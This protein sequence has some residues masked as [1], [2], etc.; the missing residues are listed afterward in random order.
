MSGGV[1]VLNGKD[2]VAM[3][4]QPYDSETL[5]ARYPEARAEHVLRVQASPRAPASKSARTSTSSGSGTTSSRTCAPAGSDSCSSRMR[6][7]RSS[8][9]SSSSST[10][11]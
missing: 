8:V 11:G 2:L 3:H 10:N 1:F 7:R 5:L 9:A 6:P 4:E